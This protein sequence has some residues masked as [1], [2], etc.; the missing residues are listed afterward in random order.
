MKAN[1]SG[2]IAKKL[3]MSQIYEDNRGV[4]PVTIIHV[5]ENVVLS[6][7]T[8][9]KD[10]YNALQLASFK[11]KTQRLKKSIKGLF[12]KAK[13]EPK[14][15]IKEFAVVKKHL[16]K[17]GEKIGVDHFKK[18]QYIDVTG[19]SIG[20]GYAGVMKRHN[21]GGLEASHGVSASHRSGGSTGQ[22]QDPGK[23]FK[24]KKM[25][26]Q[27]GNKKVT[28]QNIQ[29]VDIDQELNLLMVKGAIPGH[30]NSYLYIRDAI[31]KASPY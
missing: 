22:C 10:G 24:G 16:L 5:D 6:I 17:V 26:G 4:V 13:V 14:K 15:K 8:E 29:I 7:K 31:K 11:Q 2:V 1:R 9:G 12:E 27:M 3:G 19:T 28:K 18:G 25:A 20:K 23:V 30:K 21:F